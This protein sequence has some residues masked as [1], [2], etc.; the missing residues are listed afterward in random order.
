MP[1]RYAYWTIL[2]DDT[3]TAFRAREREELLPTFHQLQRKNKN[4]AMQWFARG[5]L[6][7]SREAEQDDF[8]RRKRAASAPF[9][10]PAAGENARRR[11]AARRDAQG[12]AR[13]LQEE[14][15]ARARVVG[16]RRPPRPREARPAARPTLPGPPRASS[17]RP[18]SER[19]MDQQAARTP[20]EAIGHGGKRSAPAAIAPQRRSHPGAISRRRPATRRSAVERQTAGRASARR[21]PLERQKPAGDRHASDR[22]WNDKP[23][24]TVRR[25]TVPGATNRLATAARRSAV[26]QQAAG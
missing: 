5:R 3:P 11:L 4:V 22:P 17:S 15:P 13:S 16:E 19:R 6:W 7:E 23:P 12:S 2:I 25:A 8:Q 24:A 10:K 1:P 18:P 20:R 21:S 9:A 14:E 26:E